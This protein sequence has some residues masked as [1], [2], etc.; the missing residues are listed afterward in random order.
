MEELLNAVKPKDVDNS[1]KED[2][3]E[4]FEEYQSA[5]IEYE[6]EKRVNAKL[7]EQKMQELNKLNELKQREWEKKRDTQIDAFRKTAPDFDDKAQLFVETGNYLSNKYGVN[8]P[9]L[10]EIS[11]FIES[12][13]NIPQLVYE[14]GNDPDLAEDLASMEPGKAIR[15]LFKME[16]GFSNGAKTQDKLPEPIK[17]TSGKGSAGKP[18]S[19]MSATELQKRLGL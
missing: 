5:V 4:T 10:V 1:P 12:S 17:S 6:A 7:Q 13:D 19:Q 14:L 16:L 9:T 3:Y 18:L 11:K 15:E 8:N 2:D